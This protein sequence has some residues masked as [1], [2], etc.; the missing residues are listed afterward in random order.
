MIRQLTR[1]QDGSTLIEGMAALVLIASVAT[2]MF[3]FISVITMSRQISSEIEQQSRELVSIQDETTQALKNN[4][5]GDPIEA[6]RAVM[7]ILQ[8]YQN[9]HCRIER[10]N[11]GLYQ[12]LY[13]YEGKRGEKEYESRI[14]VGNR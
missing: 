13:V 4:N 14:F 7:L 9:W 10:E 6:E 3:S 1:N 8:K 5:I 2:L 11:Q 12:L